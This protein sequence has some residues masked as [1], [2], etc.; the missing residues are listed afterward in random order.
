MAVSS[1]L[2]HVQ[3]DSLKGKH[4]S[5]LFCLFTRT[6]VDIDYFMKENEKTLKSYLL[7]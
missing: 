7:I 6:V 2:P 1:S 3:C 5:L 4:S